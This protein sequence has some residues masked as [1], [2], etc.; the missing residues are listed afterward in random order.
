MVAAA[1]ATQRAANAASGP[2]TTSSNLQS[3][4][5]LGQG[6]KLSLAP[7]SSSHMKLRVIS[8]TKPATPV[9]AGSLASQ[10][11]GKKSQQAPQQSQGSLT[12]V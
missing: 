6:A 3:T 12:Q 11:T 1:S 9:K 10:S 5:R 7:S 2:N 8:K 4:G